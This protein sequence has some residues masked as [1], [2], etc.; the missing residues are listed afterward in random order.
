MRIEIELAAPDSTSIC[1]TGDVFSTDPPFQ[2]WR[3]LAVERCRKDTGLLNTIQ[4][5][6]VELACPPG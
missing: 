6:F 5:H 2:I 3:K 1:W 4:N